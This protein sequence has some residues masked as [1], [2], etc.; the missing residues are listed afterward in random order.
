MLRR[1]LVCPTL[2]G[3]RLHDGQ[4]TLSLARLKWS[5]EASIIRIAVSFF[6]VRFQ[7]PHGCTREQQVITRLIG[8]MAIVTEE[9]AAAL[10][11]KE[12]L[13]AISITSQCGHGASGV[14]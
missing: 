8:K 2:P 7:P 3:Q 12:Q 14:Q 10:M 9:L 13:V 6:F 5:L 4:A 11:D 1:F